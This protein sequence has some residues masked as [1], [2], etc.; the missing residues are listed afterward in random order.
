MLFSANMSAMSRLIMCST[1]MAMMRS[2]CLL[3]T[4]VHR[5]HWTTM[6]GGSN[7]GRLNVDLYLLTGSLIL[8]IVDGVTDIRRK[9]ALGI[10]SGLC[11]WPTEG[12]SVRPKSCTGIPRS[13]T[14]ICQGCDR[15]VSLA[16]RGTGALFRVTQCI[17]RASPF[18]YNK[19][20]R[21]KY[22]ERF[23]VNVPVTLQYLGLGNKR[24][25][26]YLCQERPWNRTLYK[27]DRFCIRELRLF[28]LHRTR[29]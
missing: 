4:F 20:I 1:R 3:T 24:R 10:L 19:L 25:V 13:G 18:Y 16:R 9:F 17:F 26:S 15:W 11:P 21:G 14:H 8:V 2:R 12:P 7:L 28:G 27:L 29:L 22:F 5:K 6:S 23:Q